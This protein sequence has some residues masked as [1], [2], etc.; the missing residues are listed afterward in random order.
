[1]GG[2]ELGDFLRARR[3]GLRPDQIGLPGTGSRRRAV[4]L[5]REEVAALASISTD[6]YT[7]LEQGRRGASEEVLH[8]LTRVLRL[9]E[10]ERAY[11]FE[12]HRKQSR[13]SRQPTRRAQPQ[14]CRLLDGLASTPAVVLGR[15][16]DVL[17]W[18]PMAAALFT[19]FA[20]LRPEDRNFVRLV[21]CDPVVRARYPQWERAARN[22]VAHLRME[23][24]R[25]PDDPALAELVR[26]LSERDQDFHRWWRA[27][28]V[29][30][31]GTGTNVVR[32]PEV[33]ELTLDWSSLTC[34]AD[35][36][37]QLFTWTAE[38]GSPSER[39]LRELAAQ[40]VG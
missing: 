37:Q 18:N 32:H 10:D 3:T 19:D 29:A 28:H 2:N 22:G 4:G 11:V 31:R 21:F 36:D 1:M 17:A 24:A 30:V 35:P 23:A 20:L 15:R 26:E 40:V 16:T 39:R 5:R 7:R 13:P 14:L 6:F 33:G 34:T 27:H 8:A 25:D 38:P 12:L 9:N